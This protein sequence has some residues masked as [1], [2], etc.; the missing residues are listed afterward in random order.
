MF[1]QSIEIDLNHELSFYNKGMITEFIFKDLY[2]Q[3]IT[4]MKKE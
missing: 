4:N 2:L 1:D 3:I